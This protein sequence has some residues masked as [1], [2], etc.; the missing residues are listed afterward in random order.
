MQIVTWTRAI[1]LFSSFK[2]KRTKKINMNNDPRMIRANRNPG[3]RMV[4]L[5]ISFRG[6]RSFFGF[7]FFIAFFVRGKIPDKLNKWII[8]KL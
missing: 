4:K 7:F 3:I 6:L 8:L 1:I 2:V 5:E